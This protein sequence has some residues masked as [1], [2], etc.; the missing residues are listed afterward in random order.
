MAL[1]NEFEIPRTS[2]RGYLQDQPTTSA[3]EK[4]PNPG[5][6]QLVDCSSPAYE[7][8]LPKASTLRGEFQQVFENPGSFSTQSVRFEE[9][10]V[11]R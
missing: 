2:V 4:I 5:Q 11:R 7:S 10:G 3:D 6:R 9:V 1:H 8:N